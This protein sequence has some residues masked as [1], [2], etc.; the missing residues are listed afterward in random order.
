MQDQL[1]APTAV[2]VRR[3]A[4]IMILL[5]QKFENEVGENGIQDQVRWPPQDQAC[6]FLH[7]LENANDLSDSLYKVRLILFLSTVNA[8]TSPASIYY[9]ESTGWSGFE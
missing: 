2:L 5:M 8:L 7:C 4:S 3:L 1:H 6:K 9:S